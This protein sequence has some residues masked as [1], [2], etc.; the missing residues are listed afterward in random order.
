MMLN[1]YYKHVELPLNSNTRRLSVHGVRDA[2]PLH[3]S[4]FPPVETKQTVTI[5]RRPPN[6]GGFD[7]GKYDRPSRRDGVEVWEYGEWAE[8][9]AR[10]RYSLGV[11][12]TLD[13]QQLWRGVVHVVHGLHSSLLLLMGPSVHHRVVLSTAT[14]VVGQ[15]K[16]VKIVFLFLLY[17]YYIVRLFSRSFARP[18]DWRKSRASV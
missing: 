4:T 5:R 14:R 13:Q 2:G 1:R 3:R 9:N 18:I 6:G 8:K 15:W 10:E 12:K 17:D 7:H 11:Y 16:S